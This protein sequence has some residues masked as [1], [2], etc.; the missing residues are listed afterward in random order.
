MKVLTILILQLINDISQEKICQPIIT[1]C[2]SKEIDSEL[3]GTY[4]H[5]FLNQLN[6]SNLFSC[7]ADNYWFRSSRLVSR[8]LYLQQGWRSR[9]LVPQA[10]RSPIWKKPSVRLVSNSLSKR[11]VLH[12]KPAT[13]REKPGSPKRSWDWRYLYAPSD[14]CGTKYW[15]L[16]KSHCIQI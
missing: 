2:F 9:H 12:S 8:Q 6:F 13:T 14:C 16:Q 1:V 10:W 4:R 15:K 7:Q 3:V 5:V 11:N